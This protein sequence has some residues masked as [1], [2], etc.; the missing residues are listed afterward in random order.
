MALSKKRI[1][2]KVGTSTITNEEGNIDI[3]TLDHLCRALAGVENLGYDL[4]LVSSGAIAVGA[5]KMRLA[6]KPKEIRMKQAAA[7][8]GQTELMHLYDKF[9]GEYGRMVGQ[10][11]LDNGD[12]LDPVRSEN[13]KNTFDALLENHIIPIVNE[14]DSVS[15]TEIESEKKLFSDNDPPLALSPTSIAWATSVLTASSVLTWRKKARSIPSARCGALF[16]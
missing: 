15:H 9:F 3:R 14:N 13:L 12:I 10:I 11:L 16:K 8:V 2:V 5:G 1:V 7:A 6:Q 4:V